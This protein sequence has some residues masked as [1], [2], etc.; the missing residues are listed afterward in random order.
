MNKLDI[1]TQFFNKVRS[2]EP[3][4]ILKR[5]EGLHTHTQLRCFKGT[6]HT[7]YHMISPA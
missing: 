2:C 1:F 4:L 6:R 3:I 5:L 7:T